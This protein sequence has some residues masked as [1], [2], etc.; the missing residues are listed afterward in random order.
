MQHS[1]WTIQLVDPNSAVALEEGIFA[2]VMVIQA[3]QPAMMTSLLTIQRTPTN[4]RL[5]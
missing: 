3:P 2:H 4:V 1:H 5:S